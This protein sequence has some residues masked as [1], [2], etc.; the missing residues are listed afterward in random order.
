MNIN[1]LDSATFDGGHPVEQYAWLR[2][3]APVYWHDE[4]DGRGFC[5]KKE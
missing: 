4:P 5:N 3:N 2:E 1:L